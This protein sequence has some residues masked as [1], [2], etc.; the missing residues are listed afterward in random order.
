MYLKISDIRDR[1][2]YAGD[3]IDNF[4]QSTEFADIEEDLNDALAMLKEFVE[5][6]YVAWKANEKITKAS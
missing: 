5:V 4:K 3:N 1:L 2:R 6:D